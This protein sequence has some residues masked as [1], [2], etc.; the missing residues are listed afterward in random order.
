[1]QN[2]QPAAFFAGLLPSLFRSAR[3]LTWSIC[4]CKP[5]PQTIQKC[6]TTNLQ[7]LFAGT[8]QV[9]P[10]RVALAVEWHSD[11]LCR[12]EDGSVDASRIRYSG[13][14]WNSARLLST[15]APPP[16]G[17]WGL[18]LRVVSFSLSLSFSLSFSFSVSLSLF[19]SFS[20]LP[21]SQTPKLQLPS[22]CAA[23][24]SEKRH[25]RRKWGVVRIGGWRD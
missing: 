11:W 15:S 18:L 7:H 14:R 16:Q 6:K 20:A 25:P 10:S 5:T 4:F 21:L 17:F 3:L 8:A 13:L 1:M 23:Q 19:L 9:L 12:E 22:F 2:C 24:K